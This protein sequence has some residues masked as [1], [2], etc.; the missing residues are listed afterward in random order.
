MT[1]IDQVTDEQWCVLDLLMRAR[2]KG[3]NRISRAELV[4]S[5]V[6]PTRAVLKLVW[7]ALT[8][9]DDLVTFTH[10]D[11]AITPAGV[12]LYEFRFGKKGMPAEPTRMADQVICLPGPE[13]Y[14]EQN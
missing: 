6:L 3:I 7:A 4:S 11:F 2:R 10:N 8:M 12:A 14:K 13:H 9:P 1:I 5:T